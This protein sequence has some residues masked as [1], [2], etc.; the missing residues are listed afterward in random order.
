MKCVYFG[1][2]HISRVL[3]VCLAGFG[4]PTVFHLSS[5][6][7]GTIFSLPQYY[8]SELL[9]YLPVVPEKLITIFGGK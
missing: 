3:N 6:R 1:Q 9:N 7:N 4:L 8:D 2:L 5:I